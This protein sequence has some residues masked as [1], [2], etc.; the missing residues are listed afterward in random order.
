[1]EMSKLMSE[2]DRIIG[3]AKTAIFITVDEKG[4]PHARWVTP[5]LLKGRPGAVYFVTYPTAAKV[6]QL[7]D[8]P[9]VSWL[10][11]SPALDR[12]VSLAGKATV[13]DNA[14]LTSEVLEAVAPRLRTFWKITED[15]HA[16]AVVETVVERAE[17]F[18]PLTGLRDKG[19]FTGRK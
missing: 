14:S 15:K 17:L 12:I 11:Q 1:M 2:L 4:A 8:N 5:G 3:Q 6:A 19:D 10:F 16:F 7:R 13:I 9:S 18:L